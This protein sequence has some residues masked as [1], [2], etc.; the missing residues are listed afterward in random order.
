MM[1][2][3]QGMGDGGWPVWADALMWIGILAFSGALIWVGSALM[4][5]AT[6]RSRQ[7]RRGGQ[8]TRERPADARPDR[9]G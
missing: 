1:S 9:R 4:T 2:G 6:R 8:G 7:P 5:R 3:Y